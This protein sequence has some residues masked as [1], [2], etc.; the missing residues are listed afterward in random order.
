MKL[1]KIFTS[2][3]MLMAALTA[4]A[5]LSAMPQRALA[6][7]RSPE[8]APA[9]Q[10]PDSKQI[11]AYIE[12]LGAPEFAIRER[13]QRALIALGFEAFDALSEAEG[14][15]DP[16]IAMQASFLV[17]QIR[18]EWTRESDPRPIQMILK[19]YEVQSDERRGA[20][21]KQLAELPA[22]QGLPWLC[23]LVRFEKSPVLSKQAALA[24]IGSKPPADE[25][26]WVR[27]AATIHKELSGTSRPAAAWLEAHL[28]T[29]TD[30]A[31]SV[32]EW[33]RLADAE[34]V[35]LEQRPQETSGPIVTDLFRRQIELLDQLGRTAETGAVIRKMVRCERGDSAS[36]VELIDWL[37]KRK[38]WDAVDLVATRF[39]ASFEVDALLTYTLCEARLAQGNREL[40]EETAKK[41]LKINGDSQQEHALLAKAL[42]DRALPIWAERELRHTISLGPLGTQ[43]DIF[44]RDFLANNLHD[45]QQDQEAGE[46]F[47]QLL[48]A[49][50]KDPAVMQRI[51]VAQQQVEVSVNQL[52]ASMLFYF[53]CDA[54]R[55]G[56]TQKRRELL[57]K[58]YDQ[59]HSNV[60]ALIGLFEMTGSEPERR[61]EL[62]KSIK[63]VI[64]QCR[65]RIEDEPEKF[66][67][68]NQIAW[69]VANTDGDL[70]EALRM[71]QKSVEL[72]RAAGATGRQLGGLY[73]TLAHCYFAKKDYARAV[74]TQEEATKLDPQTTSI[75]RALVKFREALKSHPQ[76]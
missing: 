44:A 31:G 19:D 53:S 56:D 29:H 37:V 10:S 74:S 42:G 24:I 26:G 30:P 35:T 50:D 75:S 25:A 63:D 7:E 71:S 9:T 1:S 43:W 22:D 5:L 16:E 14:N 15:S 13:A 27:R 38:A 49:A 58:A 36:L 69:L 20:K 52:R 55:Q 32:A 28:Q 68:Y 59:D 23:R 46:I 72:A 11:D 57:D 60:E 45:R 33:S 41:A 6:A 39:A 17:R 18:S 73:D 21:I 47:K 61:A 12:Q 51:R 76:S 2:R 65:L 54:G 4:A 40:A 34:R 70:D 62:R 48:D 64:D 3:L 8:T 67:F 66:T